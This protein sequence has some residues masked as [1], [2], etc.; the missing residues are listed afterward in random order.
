[1]PA[2]AHDSRDQQ[3]G[4]MVPRGESQATVQR[5][6]KCAGVTRRCTHTHSH[7]QRAR[8]H[9]HTTHATNSPAPRRRGARVT[10]ECRE[11]ASARPARHT[12]ML[13]THAGN[14]HWTQCQ[15][16]RVAT[17]NDSGARS[18]SSPQA[19]SMPPDGA[20]AAAVAAAARGPGLGVSCPRLSRSL[21]RIADWIASTTSVTS[22][23]K[24]LHP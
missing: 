16:G 8:T 23:C 5:G 1:M 14:H 11:G 18:Q 4:A 7:N 2:H 22:L 21:A 3:S 6:C 13:E 17:M 20:A 9:M 10:P 24:R 19:G 15:P 12:Y